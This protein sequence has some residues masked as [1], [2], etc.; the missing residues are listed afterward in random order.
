[1]KK[2]LNIVIL[3]VLSVLL[4]ITADALGTNSGSIKTID[5]QESSLVEQP[6]LAVN[7][8]PVQIKKIYHKDQLIGVLTSEEELQAFLD[9]IYVE[10]YQADFPDTKLGLGED[11]FITTEESYITYENADT[12]IFDYLR[13]YSLFSVQVYKI[14]FSNGAIIYVKN[15]DLF[16]EAKEQYLLNFISFDAYELLKRKL[17]PAE[18]TTYGTRE[19]GINVIETAE[20]SP[21]MASVNEILKTKSE[22]IYFLSYGYNDVLKTYTVKTYDT[23]EYIAYLSGMTAQQLISI[24]SDKLQSENQILIPGTVL[25]VS[26]FDSPLSVVVTKERFAKEIVY[27][28]TTQYVKDSSIREGLSVIKTREKVGYK[29]VKYI[30]KYVNGILVE[31]NV[32]SSVITKQP[33]REVVLIGTKIIPHIGSGTLRWPIGYPRYITCAF[34]CYYLNGSWHTGLDMRYSNSTAG[35]IYA[36]DR[37]RVEAVGY[38][39]TSGY[40]VRINHNNGM[41]TYYAHMRSRSWVVE[42]IVVNKGEAIGTIGATG[43]ATGYHL[44]FGVQVNGVWVNPCKYLYC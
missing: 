44:H 12:Y 31:S 29:N 2:I 11:I 25:N 6:V 18:L 40:Y 21:A 4:M 8:Q 10:K 43:V 9:S 14:K 41:V 33:I 17:M 19:I 5:V 34:H 3:G 35:T 23:I 15:T 24:N 1:M 38:S 30:E 7:A 26:Y 32:S 27:P 37:G 28:Q 22:I 36:A 42:G 13:E 16:E 20:Y 39:S